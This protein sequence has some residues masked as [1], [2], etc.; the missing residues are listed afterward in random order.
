MNT[1]MSCHLAIPTADG[2]ICRSIPDLMYCIADR[3]YSWLYFS[4]GKKYMVSRTLKSLEYRLPADLF[5]RIHSRYLTNRMHIVYFLNGGLNCVRMT[6]GEELE[7]SR[8]NQKRLRDQ[9]I[10]L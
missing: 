6:N 8:R 3:N 2:Y 7:I 5:I 4:D 1:E 9:Y 10:I